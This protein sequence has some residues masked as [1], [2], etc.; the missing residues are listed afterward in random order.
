MVLPRLRDVPSGHEPK[1]ER[2]KDS[3]AGRENKHVTIDVNKDVRGERRARASD[4]S[5]SKRLK[6][7]VS[8]RAVPDKQ[9]SAI[10][11]SA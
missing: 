4:R 6:A 1:H 2:R 10:S 3:D 5:A 11:A 8:P 7:M 9:R